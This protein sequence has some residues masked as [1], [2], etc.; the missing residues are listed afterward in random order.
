MKQIVLFAVFPLFLAGCTVF[1]PPTNGDLDHLNKRTMSNISALHDPAQAVSAQSLFRGKEGTV[2]ALQI[3][4]GGLL[5]AHVTQVAALL[6]CAAGEAIYEDETG[7]RQRLLS[8]DYVRIT[9]LVEHW[10]SG[11][12][13]SQ[14]LLIK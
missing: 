4:Q 2:A 1:Q 7:V 13:D 11:V 10:V 3:N 5:K 8:G 6:L 14:L 12:K 9:P